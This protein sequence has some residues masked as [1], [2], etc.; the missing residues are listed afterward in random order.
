M[1]EVR[2]G[3][4]T[5]IKVVELAGMGP[6][7]YG[8]MLLADLGADVVRVDR[9]GAS[10]PDSP[11]KELLGRGRR[12]ITVDLKSAA[13]AALVRRL[14]AVADALIDPF[15]PGVAERLGIGPE[16]C[17]AANPRLVY[18][19]MTG[20]GQSGPLAEHAG[21]DINY[22]ALAG[23]LAHI[24]RRNAPP[25]PPLN[26]VGDMGGGGLMLAFGVAAALVER[27]TSGRG[28]VLD[29]AMVDGVASL[30]TMLYGYL[31]QGIVTEDRGANVF[32]SGSHFYEVYECSDGRYVAIGAIEPHF[33]RN[34]VEAIG[35]DPSSLPRRGDRSRWEESKE[36]LAGAFRAR[37]RDEWCEL[38]ADQPDLCFSPVLTMSEAPHHPHLRSRE[39]F[40]DIDGVVHP[41][42]APRFERTTGAVRHTTTVPGEH[43]EEVLDDWLGAGTGDVA[44]P[45]SDD[46]LGS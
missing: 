30:M 15:R 31:Q 8:A 17:T 43:T 24:G 38:L 4:L 32:D 14:A 46:A 9:A 44:A 11:E 12:S 6:G 26:L 18:A 27:G 20:F 23:A 35:L 29:V 34:L 19:R 13:G 40:L 36:I 10:P 42:P 21:H 33:F 3:P 41:A 22:V 37:T 25:V 2:R 28:Q 16:E 39:T 45:G 1:S 7:P 5:G